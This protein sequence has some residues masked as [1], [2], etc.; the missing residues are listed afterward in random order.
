MLFVA[1]LG[2]LPILCG[3]AGIDIDFVPVAPAPVGLVPMPRSA[4]ID[5]DLVLVA[6]APVGL[7]PMPRS[8]G[9]TVPPIECPPSSLLRRACCASPAGPGGNPGARAPGRSLATP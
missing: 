2:E 7:V 3:A 4:G 1:A 5:I 6:P 8:A 9:I